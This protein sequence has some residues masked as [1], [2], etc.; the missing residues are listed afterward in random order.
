MSSLSHIRSRLSAVT[1]IKQITTSM[2]MV[3]SAR[4]RKAQDKAKQAHFYISKMQ[5][6]LE[7]ISD[8]SQEFKHPL[9]IERPVKK[10]SLVVVTS[11]RGLCGSYNANILTMSDSFLKEQETGRA[12]LILLGKKGIQHYQRK[13]WKIDLA[14]PGW[15]GKIS[16]EQIR[17]LSEQLVLNFLSKKTDAVWIVYTKFIALMNREVTLEKFLPIGKP[18]AKQ[19]ALNYLFEPQPEELFE[20]LLPR[21]CLTKIE[22]VLNEAYASELAARIFSMKAAAKNA[23]EMIEHLTL[24]RNKMRQTSITREL[25]ETTA[26]MRE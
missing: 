3:A 15:S 17:E 8:A 18:E 13:Q 16:L 1:N 20:H 11:D 5:E 25:L 9:F 12:S 4:F 7:R 2:E 23:E 24:E 26:S 10:I 19:K 6:I 14:L 21:Y 22:T